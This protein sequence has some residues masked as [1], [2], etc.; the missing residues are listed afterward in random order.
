M[1]NNNTFAKNNSFSDHE[2]D[3]ISH[4]KINKVI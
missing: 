1:E 2:E 4:Q 3:K